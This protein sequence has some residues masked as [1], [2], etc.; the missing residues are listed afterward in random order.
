MYLVVV[1]AYS[2]WPQVPE[3]SSSS[4]TATLRELGMLFA[5]FGNPRVIV[6][7]NGTQ[8]ATKK[9]QGFC[10]MQGIEHKIKEGGTSEKLAE[11]LQCYRRTPCASTPGH[12]SPA[13]VFLGRQLRTSLTLLIESAN[14]K[15]ELV[16]VRDYRPRHEK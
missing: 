14:K 15:E 2:N 16:W 12:L 11:F 1:D 6:S 5:R 7:D 13:E 10:D 3:M 4:T 9:I 8:F